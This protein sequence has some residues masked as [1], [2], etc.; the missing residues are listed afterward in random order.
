MEASGKGMTCFVGAIRDFEKQLSHCSLRD[1][2][3]IAWHGIAMFG[4]GHPAVS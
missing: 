3:G 2:C 4:G 1:L